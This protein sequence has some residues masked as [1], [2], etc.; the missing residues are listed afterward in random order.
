VRL[1]T[2][3]VNESTDHDMTR[4]AVSTGH[5]QTLPDALAIGE[6]VRRATLAATA[7]HMIEVM[8]HDGAKSRGETS[9]PVA[10]ESESAA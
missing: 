10:G 8:R 9:L 6:R 3:Y 7:L 5:R 4:R 1:E 2:V